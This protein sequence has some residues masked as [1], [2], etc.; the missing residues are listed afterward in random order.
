MPNSSGA[1][2]SGSGPVEATERA[3]EDVAIR[4]LL[5]GLD[6]P[7]LQELR[8]LVE[9]ARAVEWGPGATMTVQ[10]PS[11]GRARLL[12]CGHPAIAGAYAV[13]SPRGLFCSPTCEEASR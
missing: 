12:T 1:T 3:A 5:D 8:R 9:L 11:D 2:R 6:V 4:F 13:S 7:T 10:L